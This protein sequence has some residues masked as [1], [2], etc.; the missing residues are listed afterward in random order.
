MKQSTENSSSVGQRQMALDACCAALIAIESVRA[1]GREANGEHDQS[2]L[3]RASGS[4]RQA[5]AALH[6]G[7]AGEIDAD[8]VGLVLSTAPSRLADRSGS[9]ADSGEPRIPLPERDSAN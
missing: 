8:G 6:P 9:T 2:T 7:D 4:L 3:E 5:I 1:H